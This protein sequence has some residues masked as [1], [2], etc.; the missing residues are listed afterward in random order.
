MPSRRRVTFLACAVAL[1]GAGAAP[2][3]D[4][5]TTAAPAVP[6]YLRF[7][8]SIGYHYSSGHYGNPERTNIQYVPLVLTAD[9]DRWRLQ[10]TIPYLH[11]SGPPV[12]AEGPFGPIQTTN[13]TSDGL[14]DLLTG[15]S[16]L[17]PM[18]RLL[19]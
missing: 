7:K 15:V 11:I 12:I 14:G 6:L 18:Y 13:G 8:A 9:I 17:V 1:C 16:Y 5:A 2:A 4:D 3:T 10:A 19:P